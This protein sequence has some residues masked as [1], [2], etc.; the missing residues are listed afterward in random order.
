MVRIVLSMALS[1]DWFITGPGDGMDR[2]LD[3]CDESG[4][5]GRSV[6]VTRGGARWAR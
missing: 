4:S 3:A 5:P 6:L 1:L 2:G